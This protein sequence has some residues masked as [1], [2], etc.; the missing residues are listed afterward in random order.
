MRLVSFS[1][2]DV[3]TLY[4]LWTDP[5]VR[6]YLWDDVVIPRVHA[7]V[8][9]ESNFANVARHGFG[10]WTIRIEGDARLAGFCGFRPVHEGPDAE[11]LYGLRAEYWGRGLATEASRLALDY[12]WKRTKCDRV[13]AIAD[14]PNRKSVEVMRRLGMRLHECNEREIT[15]VLERPG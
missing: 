5:D 4:D 12:L 13:F 11:L 3:D 10:Y 14:A 7:A 1:A 8:V 6:R 15:Y 9:V 2:G